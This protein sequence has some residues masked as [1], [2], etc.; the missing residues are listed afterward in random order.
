MIDEIR[1]WQHCQHIRRSEEFVTVLTVCN[2]IPEPRT[3]RP[4]A[5]DTIEIRIT[6]TRTVSCGLWPRHM[7]TCI[8][9]RYGSA[10]RSARAQARA[11][12]PA[13][14]T[15][16]RNSPS[17]T[18]DPTGDGTEPKPRKQ[19]GLPERKRATPHAA[20]NGASS[21]DA[22]QHPPEAEHVGDAST[23]S[24]LERRMRAAAGLRKGRPRGH[25]RQRAQL[26]FSADG[27]A[28]ARSDV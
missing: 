3:L 19:C 1:G 24:P 2:Q 22:P 13:Q 21:K 6:E 5:H 14:G 20:G 9:K 4:G 15:S 17:S 12:I 26:A 18:R 16:A 27:I 11:Q 10:L 8:P 7:S 25:V 28:G 23:G